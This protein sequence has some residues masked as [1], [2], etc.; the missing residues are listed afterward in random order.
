MLTRTNTKYMTAAMICLGF[1]Q[2]I[3]LLDNRTEITVS[4]TWELMEKASVPTN[5]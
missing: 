1:P 4:Q 3:E 5:S 2:T